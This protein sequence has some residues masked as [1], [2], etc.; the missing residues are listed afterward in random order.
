MSL[1]SFSSGICFWNF[2]QSLLKERVLRITSILEVGKYMTKR[3][4]SGL[5]SFQ[6]TL[7]CSF[8][9]FVLS[10]SIPNGC[11]MWTPLLILEFSLART[12]CSW[13]LCLRK[14]GCPRNT[15]LL[16]QAFHPLFTQE[17]ACWL[18][19]NKALLYLLCIGIRSSNSLSRFAFNFRVIVDKVR[20][21]QQFVVK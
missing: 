7:T 4:R 13:E 10:Q 9:C 5:L 18:S 16:Y 21:G 15:L 2:L 3:T 19:E 11:Y 12:P 17:L 20:E 6:P 1:V 14:R 8:I